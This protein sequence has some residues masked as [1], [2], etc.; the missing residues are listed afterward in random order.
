MDLIGCKPTNNILKFQRG[1][2]AYGNTL[3]FGIID[4]F[5]CFQSPKPWRLIKTLI[6]SI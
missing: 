3:N 5:S 1:A 6:W 2:E 4:D